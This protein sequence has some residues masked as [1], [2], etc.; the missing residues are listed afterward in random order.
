MGRLNHVIHKKVND[1][2][3]EQV[4][5]TAEMVKLRSVLDDSEATQAD[6]FG[7]RMSAALDKF[8]AVAKGMGFY[9]L[10]AIRRNYCK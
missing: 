1:N 3:P 2:F 5:I 4:K 7:A 6:P 8:L 10:P 9:G